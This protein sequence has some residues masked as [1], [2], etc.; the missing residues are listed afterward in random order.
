M[1]NYITM[2]TIYFTSVAF[3]Q[4]VMQFCRCLPS[5]SIGAR[6]EALLSYK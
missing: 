5:N 4:E 1:F 2:K 3:A 6:M